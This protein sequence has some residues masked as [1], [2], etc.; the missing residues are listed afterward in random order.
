MATARP[1]R[2]GVISDSVLT[3]YGN[4][5][6]L[7]YAIL[8]EQPG[9]VLADLRTPNYVVGDALYSTGVII[10][11]DQRG[12]GVA[13]PA[14]Q[15]TTSQVRAMVRASSESTAVV[16]AMISPGIGSFIIDGVSH[17]WE[18]KDR[19]R[20][21]IASGGYDWPTG[22]V[23]VTVENVIGRPLSSMHDLAIACAVLGAAGH[24]APTV[25]ADVLMLG[26]CGFDSYLRPCPELRK[27][28]RVAHANGYRTL[29]VPA[30]QAIGAHRECPDL[31]VIGVRH[32]REAIDYL[33]QQSA[34]A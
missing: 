25:A 3:E 28:V 23:T 14:D 22:R 2:N 33:K 11:A 16:H 24:F 34:E 30:E 32:L 20:K 1:T 29:I 13:W 31:D 26:E 10:D 9:D 8:D 21:A 17:E 12:R 6:N 7:K 5:F 4:P 18:S 15:N 27:A 19:I